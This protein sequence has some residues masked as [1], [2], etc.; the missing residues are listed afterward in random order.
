MSNVDQMYM[1]RAIELAKYGIGKTAPNPIVGAVIVKDGRIIGE[2]YHERFGE[3][4][5]E[6]NA[7][8]NATEDIKNA[9]M[10]VTLE[11]CSHEGKT[12][13][14][15]KMLAKTGIKKVIIGMKDPNPIVSGKGIKILKDAGIEVETGILEDKCKNI[16]QSYIKYITTKLPY[17]GIKTAMTLDGK[18]ASYTG[19]SKWISNET[20]RNA[21]QKLRN[22]Y[23]AVMVGKSTV[24]MDNPRLTCRLQ[25]G[26]DPVKIIVDTNLEIPINSQVFK[27]KKVILAIGEY[28]NEEKARPYKEIGVNI[29]KL[30][31]KNNMVDLKALFNKLG[32]IGISSVLVEGGGTLNFSLLKE[33]LIDRF[34]CFIAP[35]I[36]GGR[37]AFSPFDGEG[38]ENIDSAVS[39]VNYEVFGYNGDVLIDSI[40]KRWG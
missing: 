13:S 3:A 4:H 36:L 25:N 34:Y 24:L 38:F 39:V 11:P 9:Y 21:V 20:S 18:T 1:S 2:G 16:N 37:K 33:G 14:C 12:P 10:Y 19:D 28:V 26:I 6:V 5:A 29:L 31:I 40:I 27:S 8:T 17:I 15:A 22:E 30:P 7:V 35:K 23:M 32:S